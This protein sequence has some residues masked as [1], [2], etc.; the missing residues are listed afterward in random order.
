MAWG[1][2]PRVKP[3]TVE[4]PGKRSIV[5][6]GRLERDLALQLAAAGIPVRYEEESISYLVPERHTRYTPDFLLP[7][8][9]YVEGKGEFTPK[10]RV[11]HLLVQKQQPGLDIRFV[12]TNPQRRLNKASQTTYAAWCEAH[13]FKYAAKRIPPAWLKEK[14]A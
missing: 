5:V 7:N 9:I 14:K 1:G 8:G 12:F 3:I 13:G 11:K 4:L 2:R 10:D 6:K